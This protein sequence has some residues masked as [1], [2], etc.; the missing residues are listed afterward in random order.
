MASK[1]EK[2]RYIEC[3]HHKVQVS[4]VTKQYLRRVCKAEKDE[5][6]YGL[7]SSEENKIYIVKGLDDHKTKHTLLHELKHAF[8]FQVSSMKDEEDICDAFATMLMRLYDRAWQEL[9]SDDDNN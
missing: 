6:V 3:A 4:F 8:D 1:K 7:Y 5:I 2:V 9:L